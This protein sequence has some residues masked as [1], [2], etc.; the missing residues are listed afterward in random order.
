MTEDPV[1]IS[2]KI[3]Q[4]NGRV[5]YQKSDGGYVE[6]NEKGAA[7]HREVWSHANGPIPDGC[8]I[9]HRNHNRAD[10]RLVNLR[11]MT[12]AEHRAHHQRHRDW[13][14]RRRKAPDNPERDVFVAQCGY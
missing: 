9:H 14:T 10:N 3:Q 5:F 12:D 2:D 11:C 6:T 7:L 1:V 13:S 8:V 4:W